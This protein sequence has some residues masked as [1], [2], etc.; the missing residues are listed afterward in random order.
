MRPALAYWP[1]TFRR[2]RRPLGTCSA[3][4]SVWADEGS[5]EP[6]ASAATVAEPLSCRTPG[7]VRASWFRNSVTAWATTASGLTP[8]RRLSSRTRT[9]VACRRFIGV[10]LCLARK[11]RCRAALL[12][13][14]SGA[15]AMAAPC[16]ASWSACTRPSTWTAP[17]TKPSDRL[18]RS[19]TSPSTTMSAWPRQASILRSAVSATAVTTPWRARSSSWNCGSMRFWPTS[20]LRAVRATPRTRRPAPRRRRT[21]RRAA[22]ASRCRTACRGGMSSTCL[23]RAAPAARAAARCARWARTR[24]RSWNTGPATAG[25]HRRRQDCHRRGELPSHR[26]DHW[27]GRLWP[28]HHDARHRAR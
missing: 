28:R 2:P 9:T 27:R 4:S 3:P 20:P 8:I 22:V 24:R 10:S 6:S 26:R 21:R 19:N 5:G 12:R 13:G 11:R 18:S 7:L 25:P 15:S 14:L 17:P 1:P 23:P 16:H